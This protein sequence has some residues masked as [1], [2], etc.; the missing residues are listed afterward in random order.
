MPDAPPARFSTMK[1]WPTVSLSFCTRMRATPSTDPPG[2]KGTTTLTVR[3][4]YVCAKAGIAT[5][6]ASAIMNAKRRVIGISR[7]GA[8]ACPGKVD[9]GF[10]I[11]TCANALISPRVASSVDQQV[12]AAN[13]AR[14]R[15]AKECAISAQLLRVAVALGR[16]RLRALAPD[17]V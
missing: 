9:A 1:D 11:R 7:L 3:A 17:R 13:V 8:S 4:G 15:G 6:P 14:V 12:L 16:A 5:D 2:G 10:P